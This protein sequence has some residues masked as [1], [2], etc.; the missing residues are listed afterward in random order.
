VD[1]ALDAVDDAIVRELLLMLVR[2]SGKSQFLM[3][4]AIS[5]L[6]SRHERLIAELRGL[7]R[8]EFAFGSSFGWWMAASFTGMGIGAAA[9]EAAVTA[10][11][12]ARGR[13]D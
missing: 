9:R 5:E 13:V 2:Q 11:S 10:V 12:V 4:L 1:K 3:A 7:R 6:C 8:Q